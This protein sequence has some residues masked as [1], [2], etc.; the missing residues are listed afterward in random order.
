MIERSTFHLLDEKKK[1]D[2]CCVLR[3]T[4]WCYFTS[5]ISCK[6][7]ANVVRF[8]TGLQVQVMMT[9]QCVSILKLF[10]VAMVGKES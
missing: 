4:T 3:I 2:A 8:I 6:E 1:L 10:Q 9:C 5:P 7:V